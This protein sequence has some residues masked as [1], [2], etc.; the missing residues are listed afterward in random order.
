MWFEFDFGPELWLERLMR[1]CSVERFETRREIILHLLLLLKTITRHFFK[2]FRE[3]II[4]VLCYKQNTQFEL[5][6]KVISKL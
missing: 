6:R 3:Y 5:K 2:L 1:C 4:T